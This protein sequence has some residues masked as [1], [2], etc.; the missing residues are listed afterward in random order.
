MNVSVI[1]D[2]CTGCHSCEQV[3]PSKSIVFK[4]NKEGFSYPVISDSCIDCSAC[5]NYCHIN[6]NAEMRLPII[7]YAAYINDCDLL[8]K[9]TSG[10]I[11]AALALN[12]IK[13]NGVVA[14]CCESETGNVNHIIID[15]IND[16][17]LLQGSKYTESNT[18]GIYI[19]VKKEL[20]DEKKVLFSGTPCQ[21]AGLKTFL[22]KEYD[23]LIT[24]DIVCH[25]VP[26]QM[27]YKEYIDWESKKNKGKIEK[28]LFRSKQ[29]HGWS[30]TYRMELKKNRKLIVKEHIATLSPYY[31]HFLQGINYRESCYK[32]K[33]AQPKR[34]SDITLCDFWGI[35]KVLP[36]FDNNNGVSGVLLN[37]E[38][39]IQA[40]E[41]INSTVS[42]KSIPYEKIM[43][44]NGQLNAPTKR[45]VIRDNY[46]DFVNENGFDGVSRRYTSIK[47]LIKDS[48][49]DL[50][51]NKLR[52]K[53]KKIVKR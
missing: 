5:L 37:T 43:N 32:C 7:C 16:I 22:R 50:I 14:G 42:Y 36:E 23:N 39:G 19:A 29:K 11:F 2:K 18:E 10:G 24:V 33:Y 34:V 41:Q 38:K 52:Q 30:L 49:K 35:E 45:T 6:N 9:S 53:I 46:Y 15:D 13:N 27:L 8:K 25:G 1:G 44:N 26:S 12:I 17:V 21:I 47:T 28:F 3:C 4:K 51:P 31:Y 40:W 48:L 20:V